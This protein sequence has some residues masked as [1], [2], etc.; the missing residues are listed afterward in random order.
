MQVPKPI[1][2][3]FK[4]LLDMPTWYTLVDMTRENALQTQRKFHKGKLSRGRMFELLDA[5]AY[6]SGL[7]IIMTHVER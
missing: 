1:E 6:S 3:H 5:A 4:D 7:K 2:D